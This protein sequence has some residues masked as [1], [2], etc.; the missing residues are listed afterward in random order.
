MRLH[1]DKEVFKELLEVIGDHY[2]LEE[3]I[4]EKDY[5]VTYSLAKLNEYEEKDLIV[6]RGGTSLTKCYQDLKRF[7]EDI[8]LAV[9]TKNVGNSSQLKRII[10][11]VEKC[12]CSL[13]KEV[14]NN[15]NVKSGTYRDVEY[16][17]PTILTNNYESF[18]ELNQFIKI[19]TVTFL[20]PNPYEKK[21]VTSMI[22]DY[23]YDNH[24]EEYIEKYNLEPFELQVLSIKRTI[25]D[26]IVSLVRLSYSDD[27][28]ELRTKTRHLYDLH[29]TYCNMKD[30]Y[31]DI[32]E[33]STI[34][35]LVRK[36]EEVSKF[37]EKYPH[38]KKWSEAPIW[39]IIS[40]GILKEDYEEKFG[41]SFVYG[42]LPPYIEVVQ[43]FNLIKQYIINV[44]E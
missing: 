13:F 24:F 14:E 10:R 2:G 9:N 39:K 17:Y 1:E 3:Q 6:F 33:L 36:D 28:S 29:L 15:R 4:I 27:I 16:K 5:W 32:N 25:I 41:R 44:G 18:G 30:F 38:A 21:Q 22:Y 20:N 35:N 42:E 26:K 37:K 19:E 7:S 8:D 31:N 43:T 40:D 11:D 12:I 34:I 23:L